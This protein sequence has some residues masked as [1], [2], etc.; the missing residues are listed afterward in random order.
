MALPGAAIG[1]AWRKQI[2]V[3]RVA[4]LWLCAFMLGGCVGIGI[5]G[6][7]EGTYTFN[8][9]NYVGENALP[10]T[11]SGA[12]A[13]SNEDVLWQL[14]GSG[15]ITFDLTIEVS[16]SVMGEEGE[17]QTS[18]CVLGI[19]SD[20]QAEVGPADMVTPPDLGGE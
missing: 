20:L 12:T 19:R 16:A 3:R 2:W 11:A 5:W 13:S 7:F 6:T 10:L 8:K 15:E 14:S 17:P 4:T 18:Q 1:L 9:A